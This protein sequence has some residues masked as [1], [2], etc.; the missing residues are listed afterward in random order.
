MIHGPNGIWNWRAKWQT[1]IA[2]GQQDCQLNTKSVKRNLSSMQGKCFVS[3]V[4]LWLMLVYSDVLVYSA[5]YYHFRVPPKAPCPQ[6]GKQL[7]I[8]PNLPMTCHP[9]IGPSTEPEPII[10]KLG[11]WTCDEC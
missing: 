10:W 9:E 1:R 4:L 2:I 11:N 7:S 5:G 6:G 3:L 8:D